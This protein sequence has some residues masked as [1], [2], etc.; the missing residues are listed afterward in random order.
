MRS[1]VSETAVAVVL[2]GLMACYPV[3]GVAA[4][5]LALGKVVPRGSAQLNGTR[6]ALETTLYAGDTITTPADGLALVLLP[7]GDQL[8]VGPASAVRATDTA[9]TLLVSLERGA[10]LARSGSGQTIAV[11]ARGLIVNPQAAARYAVA[12]TENAVVVSAEQGVVTVQ[13]TAQTYTVPA[14]KT[15]RFEVADGPQAPAGA[16]ASGLGPG[17]AA[18][19][20]I[21]ISVGAAIPIGFVIADELADDARKDA[22]EQVKSQVSPASAG[23]G[24]TCK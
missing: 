21:I 14:G 19:V 15:M 18:I 24:I 8:H 10:L 16:G 5:N 3:L 11:R 7:Q 20:A 6:L 12:L 4:D 9:G 17:T 1:K 13:G 22:C 23:A 2:A